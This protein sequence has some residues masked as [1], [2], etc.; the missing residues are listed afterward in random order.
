MKTNL[1][2]IAISYSLTS[3]AAD[4]RLVQQAR[5]N[6]AGYRL[7]VAAAQGNNA[8]VQRLLDAGVPVD[9][10]DGIGEDNPLICAARQG[11]TETVQLLL[12]RGSL[13]GVSGLRAAFVN[14]HSPVVTL[15]RTSGVEPDDATKE[16]A[17]Q[18]LIR[19]RNNRE[20]ATASA[21]LDPIE[22]L[23]N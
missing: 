21:L 3:L 14:R 18:L 5:E 6:S 19:K 13:K 10:P 8:E 4:Y 9:A 17:R 20:I 16:E 11:H 2:I 22:M 7:Q 23:G 12:Q 15:L 1:F